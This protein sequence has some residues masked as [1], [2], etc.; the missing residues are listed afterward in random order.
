MKAKR[1][2]KICD[3]DYTTVYM[4]PNIYREWLL[5]R[6][7]VITQ[8]TINYEEAGEKYSCSELIENII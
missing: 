8:S 2:Q 1:K 3:A 4:C 7:N 6:R 5:Y